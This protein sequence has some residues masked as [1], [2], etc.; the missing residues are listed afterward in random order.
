MS[1]II[2]R[3]LSC[4][5]YCWRKQIRCIIQDQLYP[6]RFDKEY[7]NYDFSF[8]NSEDPRE[9]WS[10]LSFAMAMSSLL[11]VPNNVETIREEDDGITVITKGSRT[12]KFKANEIIYFDKAIPDSLDVY[13][14]FDTRSM[15]LHDKAEILD[16][17]DFVR[18]I[19][20]YPSPRSSVAVTKDLVASSRMTTEQLL[21]P[22]YGNGIVRLKMLRMLKSEGI[23]GPL[24]VKTEKKTY[25][26]TPKIEFFKRV[27][28]ERTQPL[29]SFDEVF[30]LEQTKGEAWKMIEK[31]RAR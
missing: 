22:A 18:Q 29:Y 1:I 2:G 28:S 21:D 24:S 20:F 11:L 12:K 23:T 7:E 3:S 15:R 5:L 19:N 27:V 31:L 9:L 13:D 30:K 25:Y 26:K 14:F 16:D 10:N 6:H 17:D 4:L 8:M